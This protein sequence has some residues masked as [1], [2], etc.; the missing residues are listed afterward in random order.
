MS[1]PPVSSSPYIIICS[2]RTEVLAAKDAVGKIVAANR[3]AKDLCSFIESTHTVAPG[4]FESVSAKQHELM[5]GM[6]TMSKREVDEQV[7]AMFELLDELEDK[8]E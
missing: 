4:D 2:G 7:E 1:D 5:D 3:C 8:F 6:G